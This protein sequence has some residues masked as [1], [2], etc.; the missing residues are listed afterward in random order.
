MQIPYSWDNCHLLPFV[1]IWIAADY[2]AHQLIFPN[3]PS[4]WIHYLKI[5][6]LWNNFSPSSC[7]AG[8]RTWL[9]TMMWCSHFISEPEMRCLLHLFSPLWSMHTMN[10]RL[11]L[12]KQL[13]EGKSQSLYTLSH[14]PRNYLLGGIFL[15]NSIPLASPCSCFSPQHHT[16]FFKCEALWASQNLLLREQDAVPVSFP[17][18]SRH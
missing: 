10:E 14:V 16:V 15:T 5:T 2:I 12:A 1:S 8:E 11:E 6:V 7:W 3:S 4:S 18:G 13:F 17:R 9:V